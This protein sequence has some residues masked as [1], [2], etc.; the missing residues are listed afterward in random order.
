MD[1]IAA[2]RRAQEL[3]PI[4][5]ARAASLRVPFLDDNWMHG[6]PSCSMADFE[7]PRLRRC[8]FNL[9][10]IDWKSSV[11]IGGGLDGYLWK[12]F[13]EGHGPYVLKVFWDVVPPDFEHYYAVQRE[14]QNTALL[15]MMQE[16]VQE[17]AAESTTILVNANP[18]TRDEA[19]ANLLAFSTEGRQLQ[20]SSEHSGITAIS[21]IPRI[22]KCY[23]WLKFSGRVFFRM[24]VSKRA[25]TIRVDKIT[26]NLSPDREYTAIVYEYIEEGDNNPAVVEE[27][28]RFLWLAGFGHTISPAARNWRAGVLVDHSD[29]V[30]PTGFGWHRNFY[31]PRNADMILV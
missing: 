17:A 20:A 26:R 15:Q 4:S 9:A 13:F 6:P 10:T 27:V 5:R 25:P 14:C 3:K 31:G 28:D 12:V 22:T 29:I 16:A 2:L 11:R 21:S 18:R 24:P 1:T 7:V 19:L 8:P 23:G 30:H